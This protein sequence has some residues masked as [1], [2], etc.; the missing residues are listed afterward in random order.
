[1]LSRIYHPSP[2]LLKTCSSRARL[3]THCWTR[4]KMIVLQTRMLLPCRTA[5]N[6][7]LDRSAA[8]LP[9]Q[10][11]SATT[12]LPLLMLTT[13][14]SLPMKSLTRTTTLLTTFWRCY[15]ALTTI[16][17]ILRM[18]NHPKRLSN[19]PRRRWM[20]KILFRELTLRRHNTLLLL[21]AIRYL[22]SSE[23]S[24]WMILVVAHNEHQLSM[25]DWFWDSLVYLKS[26]RIGWRILT[27]RQ[28]AKLA[29][30][31]AT[32]VCSIT[33]ISFE[34][35]EIKVAPLKCDFSK[36][37]LHVPKKGIHLMKAYLWDYTNNIWISY[38]LIHLHFENLC[39]YAIQYSG[40]L[41]YPTK[42]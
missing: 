35:L 8:S 22:L 10:K 41:F 19:Q 14:R 28:R 3:I 21:R 30:P 12:P 31:R 26:N 7:P 16:K 23:L 39:A 6:H 18:K 33:H 38:Y 24:G 32:A 25:F 4:W 9:A 20:M 36:T 29:P 1:M 37:L 27:C 17:P 42:N 2:I 34:Y 5:W 40:S 13:M 15:W 11:S